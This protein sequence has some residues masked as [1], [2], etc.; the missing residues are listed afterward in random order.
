MKLILT[1]SVN[2]LPVSSKIVSS[3]YLLFYKLKLIFN[4]T[5]FVENDL[6]PNIAG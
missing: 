5:Y 1:L 3:K 4:Y 6:V 2:I